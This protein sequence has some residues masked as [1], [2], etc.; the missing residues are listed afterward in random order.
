MRHLSSGS[1]PQLAEHPPHLERGHHWQ[2]S[3]K[4]KHQAGKQ[5]KRAKQ[6]SEQILDEAKS[7][8]RELL[9]EARDESLRLKTAAEAEL[10]DRRLGRPCDGAH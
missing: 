5:T 7:K 10:R 6:S 2:Q 9:L 4:Q 8:Q 1:E 3:S